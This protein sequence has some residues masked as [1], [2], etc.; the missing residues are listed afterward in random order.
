MASGNADQGLY[1]T[2]VIFAIVA[3]LQGEFRKRGKHIDVQKNATAIVQL[4]GAEKNDL[5]QLIVTHG[6]TPKDLVEKLS[7]SNFLWNTVEN[8]FFIAD[9]MMLSYDTNRTLVE[10]MGGPS[11]LV[12]KQLLPYLQDFL[13]SDVSDCSDM[14][15]MVT[16]S[17]LKQGGAHS[18]HAMRLLTLTGRGS[19]LKATCQNSWGQ[20]EENPVVPGDLWDKVDGFMFLRVVEIEDV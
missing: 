14:S 20:I 10:R 2:C 3:A 11:N 16:V 8:K 4:L 13:D 18:Y 1:G 12:V 6:T 17:G 9:I 5:G 7:K 19:S 15:A